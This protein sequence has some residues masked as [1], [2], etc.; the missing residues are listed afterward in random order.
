LKI[1]SKLVFYFRKLGF[2]KGKIDEGETPVKCA[3][4]EVWE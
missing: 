2:P 3:V 4:R 1:K